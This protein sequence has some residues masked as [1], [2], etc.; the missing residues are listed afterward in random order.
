MNKLSI[1]LIVTSQCLFGAAVSVAQQTIVERP[2]EFSLPQRLYNELDDCNQNL[3][4]L[5]GQAIAHPQAMLEV[6]RTH[7]GLFD[8]VASEAC[9]WVAS[10]RSTQSVTVGLVS[11]WQLFNESSKQADRAQ[12]IHLLSVIAQQEAAFRSSELG[13][14]VLQSLSNILEADETHIRTVEARLASDR[15]REDQLSK[16]KLELQAEIQSVEDFV[17]QQLDSISVSRSRLFW[18]DERI[19]SILRGFP[20]ITSLDDAEEMLK[21]TTPWDRA[22]AFLVEAESQ[23]IARKMEI[24]EGDTTLAKMLTGLYPLKLELR[25][26]EQQLLRLGR[27]KEDVSSELESAKQRALDTLAAMESV[28]DVASRASWSRAV[29]AA[30]EALALQ[31]DAKRLAYMGEV[32]YAQ[33]ISRLARA[34]ET[35]VFNFEGQVGATASAAD[36]PTAAGYPGTASARPA[37]GRTAPYDDSLRSLSPYRLPPRDAVYPLSDDRGSRVPAAR[38]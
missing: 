35:G 22:H 15:A 6:N 10:P 36:K 2:R 31:L 29:Q 5:A 21:R 16:R 13:S 11:L 1:C 17:R 27:S 23:Q 14:L 32:R 25:K 33:D 8:W 18:S 7:V 20:Q 38:P 24:V 4:L 28:L 3:L 9:S 34:P 19:L 26:A 37:V 30:A 12:F